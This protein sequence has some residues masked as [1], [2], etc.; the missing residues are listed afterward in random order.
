MSVNQM[1]KVNHVST[2]L[3]Q[4]TT[5]IISLSLP[6]FFRLL[7]LY[8]IERELIN[9]LVRGDRGLL[10]YEGIS[11]TFRTESIKKWTAITINTRRWEATRR[12]MAAKLTRLTHKIAIPL[13]LVAE[14]CT[15]CSSR[16]RR[17]VRKLF[18]TPSYTSKWFARRDWVKQTFHYSQFI[19]N[20]NQSVTVTQILSPN[21]LVFRGKHPKMGEWKWL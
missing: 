3:K 18:D 16:S 10:E 11:K 20:S 2:Y 7:P 21:S 14:S 9:I 1:R 12:V 8:S 4:K 13:H 19:P 15:I 17:P 5:F 6:L